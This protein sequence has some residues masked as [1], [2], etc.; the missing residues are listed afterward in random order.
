MVSSFT[1][2]LITNNNEPQLVELFS[3]SD[4]SITGTVRFC[5]CHI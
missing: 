1:R 4:Q 3:T 5:T 2:F